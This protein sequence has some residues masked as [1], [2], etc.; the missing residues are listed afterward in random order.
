MRFQVVFF[1]F[2][3]QSCFTAMLKI[4]SKKYIQHPDLP[5]V[6]LRSWVDETDLPDIHNYD[7]PVTF[8]K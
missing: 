8:G 5:M 2:K 1:P 3:E 4:A 7:I 6:K